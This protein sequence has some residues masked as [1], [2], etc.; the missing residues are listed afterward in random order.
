ML[1]SSFLRKARGDVA[2]HVVPHLNKLPEERLSCVRE[3]RESAD[4]FTIDTCLIP[5]KPTKEKH[6]VR[7]EEWDT[8][9]HFGSYGTRTPCNALK[10]KNYFHEFQVGRGLSRLCGPPLTLQAGA[11]SSW[12]RLNSLFTSPQPIYHYIEKRLH[13]NAF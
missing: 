3:R 12:P 7:R 9:S 6:R 2:P 1:L 4:T 10:G 13:S 11:R 5:F 8:H